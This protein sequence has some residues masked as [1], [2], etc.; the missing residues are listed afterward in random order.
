MVSI[1]KNF[2]KGINCVKPSLIERKRMNSLTISCHG[3]YELEKTDQG[4]LQTQDI[5]AA[6]NELYSDYLG[7]HVPDDRR[8][9]LQDV[10]WG[11]G[12]LAISAPTLPAFYAAQL[13]DRLVKQHTRTFN[14]GWI[15]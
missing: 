10:H 1:W 15:P 8:G 7:V 11:H 12:S 9:C 14:L 13:Y 4:E 3:C 2:Y 5:P 6:W